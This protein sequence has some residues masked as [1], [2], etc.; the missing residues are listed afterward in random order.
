MASVGL[1]QQL[2]VRARHYSRGRFLGNS[3]HFSQSRLGISF[4]TL[5]RKDNSLLVSCNCVMLDIVIFALACFLFPPLIFVLLVPSHI[6]LFALFSNVLF[7]TL[8]GCFSAIKLSFFFSV[9]V[10]PSVYSQIFS[11]HLFWFISGLTCFVCHF[12]KTWNRVQQSS[13]HRRAGGIRICLNN[14][15]WH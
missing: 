8:F 7:Y 10:T 6:F 9:L 13:Y 2:C 15:E 4:K 1:P 11:F 14:P 3:I 5:Q 12:N